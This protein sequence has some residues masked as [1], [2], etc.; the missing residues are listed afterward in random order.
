MTRCREGACDWFV[1]LLVKE[2]TFVADRGALSWLPGGVP[3]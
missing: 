2:Q 3:T 1:P